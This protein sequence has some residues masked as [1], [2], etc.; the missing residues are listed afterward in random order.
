MSVATPAPRTSERYQIAWRRLGLAM[1]TDGIPFAVACFEPIRWMFWLWTQPGYPTSWQVAVPL[2]SLLIA[3]SRMGDAQRIALELERLFPDPGSPQRRGN[4]ALLILGGLVLVS[5]HVAVSPPAAM[6]GLVCT[7]A[8][9]ALRRFGPFVM[10]AL[11]P[12][13][14]FLLLAVP[15]PHHWM[16]A[17][18]GLMSMLVNKIAGQVLT[19]T[20]LTTQSIGAVLYVGASATPMFTGQSLSGFFVI[21]ATM[22]VALT[23]VLVSRSDIRAALQRLVLAGS[24]AGV[25]NFT[26]I[27]LLAVVIHRSGDRSL[28]ALR[29]EWVTFGI[30]VMISELLYR[31]RSGANTHLAGAP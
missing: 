19:A 24:V 3:H 17:L 13:F 25:V 28:L 22:A 14:L 5:A 12:A 18:S 2:G 23:R 16:N 29:L 21:P 15:F 1:V 4:I 27:C 20:G 9:W 8:G 7:C 31:F 30:A 6:V 11:V 26:T 10:R